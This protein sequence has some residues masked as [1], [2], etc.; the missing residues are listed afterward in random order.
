M[1]EQTLEAVV[2]EIAPSLAGRAPGKVFQLGRASLALDFRDGDGRQLFV[3]A[4]PH[5]PRLYLVRRTIRELEKASHASSTFALALRKHL[6][7]ASL[8]AV[9]K[10]EGER[11]VRFAFS[12]RDEAGTPRSPVLVAQL[13][14]RSANLFLLDEEGR[15]VESL[16]PAQAEGQ[17]PGDVYAPPS[18][19]PAQAHASGAPRHERQADKPRQQPPFERGEFA[20]LS[21]A[22]DDYYRR[23]EKERAFDARA[24]AARSRL[25]AEIEKRRRLRA[26]LER[27]LSAHGDADE[28]K[29]AGD[30][31]LANL[32]NAERHGSVV[33][34]ADYFA[35]DAPIVELEVDDSLTLPE[36]A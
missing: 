3:S 14:G 32:A 16:R 20:T 33:R 10:D 24:A 17:R 26:N 13:T 2:A 30:L 4:E 12:A 18:R 31:L 19:V 5:A 29:R 21:E 15:V 1:N 23:A 7:G 22:L 8:R 36:E 35:D 9:A 11:V 25:R 6:S 27:D 28:H 34:L